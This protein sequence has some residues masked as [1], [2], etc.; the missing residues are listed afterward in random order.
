[1]PMLIAAALIQAAPTLEA[2]P[3]QA[4]LQCRQAIVTGIQS[5]PIE[6]SAQFSYFT[7]AAARAMPGES[8]YFE[9]MR[10]V[11]AP[12]VGPAQL[13]PE[14]ARALV[15]ACDQR[16]PLAR[17]TGPVTLPTDPFQRD[18]MCAGVTSTLSGTARGY[19]ERTGDVAP[20][21]R[22]QSLTMRFQAL[23]MTGMAERGMTDPSAQRRAI[24][25]A[26]F[27]SLDIGNQDV[28]ANACEAQAPAS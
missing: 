19:G 18:L 7:M 1:M 26:M 21:R 28:I 20:F 3:Y 25:E 14:V 12:N 5:L 24:G 22:L 10:A 13:A 11:M 8:G 27:A 4:A 17:R 9:R 6:I 23:V 16:F 2:D 15:V